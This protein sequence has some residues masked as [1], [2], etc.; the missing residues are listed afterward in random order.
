M[1]FKEGSMQR[2][3]L[4]VGCGAMGSALAAVWK[5]LHKLTIVDPSQKDCLKSID[6][7]GEN[8][9]PEAIILAVKPQLLPEII[10]AYRSRFDD[11]GILWI[12]IAAGV[13]I[14]FFKSHL[15]ANQRVVRV[16]PNLPAR[17]QKGMSV[18]VS[19]HSEPEIAEELFSNVGEIIWLQDENQMDAVTAIAGSGPAYFYLMVEEL[20]KSGVELGLQQEIASLL[21]RQTAIGAGAVLDNMIESPAI[22]RQQVTSPNGT[23]AAA[24]SSLMETNSPCSLGGVLKKATKAARDRAI[25]LGQG[26]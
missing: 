17:F 15:K 5:K 6:E 23:T 7:I 10:D 19:N 18:M 1:G 2:K 14:S 12:S 8:Y 24:L 26:K 3:V 9:C 25:E 20:E 4:M 22:L 13:P 21:A 11:P 16:M